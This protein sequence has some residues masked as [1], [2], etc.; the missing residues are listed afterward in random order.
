MPLDALAL[1][2]GAA[3][4]HALWNLLLAREHD[5][6]AASA[7]ALLALVATLA[8]PAALTWRVEGAAVPFIA[9]SAVLELVYVALLA[10][11]YRRYE[12]SLVYP[13]ARGLAPVLA[14]LLVVA[15]GGARPSAMGIVG[16]LAVAAGV[17]FVR[18]ARGSLR[19][20]AFGAAIASAIAGYTVVDRYG[21]RH[22]AAGPYLLLVMLGPALA[23]P[24]VV[25][26]P[27][28]RS[29]LGPATLVVGAASASAYL[30]VLLALRLASAPAVAAVRET[31]VVMATAAAALVLRERVGAIRL[32]GAALVASG[33]TLLALS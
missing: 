29:A 2:L 19:G 11:A 22:A 27:R 8:L 31:S 5:T 25:G 26:W 30:L 10:A 4:L 18:G 1:A 23:Y 13:V 3:A 33:V 17:L 28:L 15:A 24:Y 16:V 32:A 9:G 21:I 12:L 20:L 14:L 7:V 6:Q